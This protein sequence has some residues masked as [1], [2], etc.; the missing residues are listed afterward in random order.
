[1]PEGGV[2]SNEGSPPGKDGDVRKGRVFYGWWIVAACATLNFYIGGAFFY[3]FGAFF[4]PIRTAFGWSYT[5]VSFANSLQRLEGGIAAPIVGFL[6]DR[7]GPRKLMLVGLAFGG[8][9]FVVLSRINS[10]WT[11]YVAFMLISAGFSTGGGAVNRATIANW[12]IRNRTKALAL[13]V[14]G[15]GASGA[16]VPVVV[17]AISRLG[18]RDTLFYIAIG[19]WVIGLPV[20]LLMRHRP[21]QYGM[22][23]DGDT[24]PDE[25]LEADG[26]DATG[27]PRE[28]DFTVR[29]ALK[30]RAYWL[31]SLTYS[32][33]VLATGAVFVHII[34]HLTIV[35][36]PRSVSG[37][38]VMGMTL[39]SLVG[40]LGFGWLGDVRD[41][42]H[43][44]VTTLALQCVGML[45]LANIGT[46]WH[47]IVFLIAFSPAYGGPIPL[48]PAITGEYFGRK[49][50]GAIQGVMMTIT[51]TGGVIGPIFAGWMCDVF[52]DYH[53]A[54]M[55]LAFTSLAA[56][57]LILAAKR[58]TLAR[59]GQPAV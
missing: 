55:I 3:G 28:V 12:F 45:I 33:Q 59:A 38:T 16:L 57:P 2:P 25:A 41:K 54:F 18:W 42:R 48:R 53:V 30:T 40:R 19:L 52:G 5:V 7:V 43:L 24:P 51:V 27:G 6:F 23:P 37:F 9:G 50:F 13:M 44:I 14:T 56:I 58:P 31:I 1:L 39:I 26:A 34:P 15:F 35:G 4:D 47:V 36:I 8:L 22:L 29:E 17:W 49:S 20:S 11:Y 32:I 21:E 46:A 10:L